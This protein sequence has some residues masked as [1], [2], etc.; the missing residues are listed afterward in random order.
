MNFPYSFL[1]QLVVRRPAAPL[2][3]GAAHRSLGDYWSDE[4]FREALYL[5]S[6]VLFHELRKYADGQLTNEKALAKLQKSLAKYFLRMSNRSTPFGLFSGC[7]MGRWAGATHLV[8]NSFARQR[9]TRLDMH[10]L[11]ALAQTLSRMPSVA[12]HLRY[13]PNTSLYAIGDELR[14]VEYHYLHGRRRHTIA[15]VARIT[16]L[17]GLLDNAKNGLRINELIEYLTEEEVTCEEARE[18]V[19]ELITEQVL[20]SELEPSITGTD[21]LSYLIDILKRIPEPHDPTLQAICECLESVQHELHQLDTNQVNDP[22]N[23]Q[24]IVRILQQLPV[25]VDEAKLFQTDCF[26]PGDEFRLDASLQEELK[27]SLQ[28]LSILTPANAGSHLESFIRR[29]TERYEDREVALL[30]AL[31]V[32]TGIGYVEHQKGDI[33]PLIQDLVL[34]PR[35]RGDEQA[36]IGLREQ[37]LLKKL[38]AWMVNGGTSIQLTDDDLPKA[39]GQ[40]PL[41]PSVPI[42]FRLLNSGRI[43]LESSGGSSAANLLGRFAHGSEPIRKLVGEICAVEQE[44]NPDV[45]FAEIV[46]LPESRVGNIL[47]H[48]PFRQY[49]IPFLSRPSTGLEHQIPPDDLLISVKNKQVLLRSRRLNKLVIPRLSSAHNFRS[50]ALPVYQFLC[51]L[52]TQGLRP[53]L[54]FHW[55]VLEGIYAHLPR[56]EYGSTVLCPAQWN[57]TQKHL[58]ELVNAPEQA[59]DEALNKL[60]KSAR[61]PERFVLADG[62]NELLI[63]VRDPLSVSIWLD[64]IRDRQRVT[65]KE[66][67]HAENGAPVCDAHGKAY[68]NQFVCVL[69]WEEATYRSVLPPPAKLPG[70]T[71]SFLPGSEWLYVKLY[72]GT[73]SA[74][75][76]LREAIVPVLE[77]CDGNGWVEQF[78]FIRYADP[79]FHLR[80]RFRLTS[81]NHLGAVMQ[82]LHS[83]ISSEEIADLVWKVQTDT[84]HRELERYG[85]ATV[86]HAEAL[87]D[88]QSRAVL[89]VLQSDNGATEPVRWL[90]LLKAIDHLLGQFGFDL[91]QKLSFLSSIKAAFHQE[92]SADAALL[93]QLAAIYRSHRKP[94]EQSLSAM[95]SADFQPLV[96]ILEACSTRSNTVIA[97]LLERHAKGILE[98]PLN[99]LLASYVHM[100]VNRVVSA[101]PRTHEL[102]LYDLLFTYYRSQIERSKQTSILSNANRLQHA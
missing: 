66:F 59:R 8:V 4:L 25:T 92:Y 68:G 80:L 72:C 40:L 86:G 79:A 85:S 27:K 7:T 52:Q 82:R 65:L 16:A 78:F 3:A 38:E 90:W 77:E 2:Q 84:Y 36:S 102:A 26:F 74:D 100:L 43:Y 15:S 99:D 97:D 24:R 58:A 81:V 19:S 95:P 57:L 11:C 34:P 5:A 41:P 42:M 30:E 23:Y 31:D 12:S 44:R 21:F 101:D 37:I 61:L 17:E 73:K 55:G 62:D 93:N 98:V 88:S 22:E 70:S 18:F 33:V 71:R 63:D 14:Y 48:P 29:F 46:H 28:L 89:A 91:P 94:I 96:A 51:E 50:Q 13:F 54:G 10:Y 9:Q 67:L 1:P 45:V 75:K 35:K 6:P 69:L 39:S 87:F 20:V 32:E 49:E 53:G 64:V 83:W 60:R 76:I 47:L 56:V